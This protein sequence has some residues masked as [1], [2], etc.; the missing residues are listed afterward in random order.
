MPLSA[1]PAVLEVNSF[2][3]LVDIVAMSGVDAIGVLSSF[4]ESCGG[5]WSP[6]AKGM[7][8]LESAEW[9]SEVRFAWDRITRRAAELAE[10]T[11]TS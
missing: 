10:G 2:G 6:P 7:P 8:R 1:G 5:P 11:T 3:D 9:R 4:I